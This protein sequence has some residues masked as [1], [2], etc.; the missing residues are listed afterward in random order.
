MLQ[1]SH[2][3]SSEGA[4]FP[5]P[6]SPQ[7]RNSS[8][9]RSNI[10]SSTGSTSNR[11]TSGGSSIS[12]GRT[13]NSSSS[14]SSSNSSRS[15]EQRSVINFLYNFG[16]QLGVRNFGGKLEYG[17]ISQFGLSS[18]WPSARKLSKAR[19]KDVGP[20]YNGEETA[21]LNG[22]R[23]DVFRAQTRVLEGNMCGFFTWLISMDFLGNKSV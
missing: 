13:S 17:D 10:S 19:S 3:E 9:S 18:S 16:A 20:C 23:M 7:T 12:S 11:I 5:A 15:R 21:L 6:R 1:K 4:L 8:S 14:N 2:E 22:C